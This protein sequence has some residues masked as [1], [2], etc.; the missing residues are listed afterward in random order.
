M[1]AIEIVDILDEARIGQIPPCADP[2]FVGEHV[3]GRPRRD[4][5]EDREP[6]EGHERRVHLAAGVGELE[7]LLRAA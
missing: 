6:I 7:E 3:A 5:V 2:G 1:A 4:P